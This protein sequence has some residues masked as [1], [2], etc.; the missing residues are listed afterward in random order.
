MDQSKAVG[1]TAVFNPVA[2]GRTLRFEAVDEGIRDRQ[3]GT[4]WN[5]LGYAVRG[6]LAGTRL[7]P[8]PH[9]DAFWFAWAAFHPSTSVHSAP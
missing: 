4:V 6:P 5:L 1:A 9:V 3:T 7:T 8:I 2:A